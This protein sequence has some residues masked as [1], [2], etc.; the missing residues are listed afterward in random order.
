[1]IISF[2]NHIYAF[3]AMLMFIISLVL[4]YPVYMFFFLFIR[5]NSDSKVY[6]ITL[7]WG[8]FLAIAFLVK[9]KKEYELYPDKNKAY[10]FIANHR[11]MLDIPFTAALIPNHFRFL[12]KESLA[13]IPLLG[14][15][16]RGICIT[17]KRE[18]LKDKSKS[19]DQ[20]KN[21]L[22]NGS[23][24]LIFPEGTRS[25]NE[26]I[27]NNFQNGAFKLAIETQVP[28]IAITLWNTSRIM[29]KKRFWMLQPGTLQCYISAPIQ[30]NIALEDLKEYCHKT[31]DSNIRK[32][33]K[34][35]II[36]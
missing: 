26:M 2:L 11:S 6:P 25:F 30:S 14:R 27:L 34:K 17:V 31:I 33:I 3:I 16:I 13:K 28:I 29:T 1:M 18:S 32:A 19:Y 23:S 35:S 21:T 7:L 20:M 22:E 10:I 12:S 4:V 5:S 36:V 15:I 8:K 9:L 24:V